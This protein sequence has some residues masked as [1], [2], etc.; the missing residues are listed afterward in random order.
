MALSGSL[1]IRLRAAI[2]WRS[3]NVTVRGGGFL[4]TGGLWV[5]VVWLRSA[6]K[7]ALISCGDGCGMGMEME[8]DGDG[9]GDEKGGENLL[10][11]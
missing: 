1:K 9:E 6:T 4:S 5:G 8:V 7:S 11:E 3:L 10:M 2:A